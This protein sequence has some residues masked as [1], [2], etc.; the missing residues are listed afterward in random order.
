MLF[1]TENNMNDTANFWTPL[2]T[3]F[4]VVY[5]AAFVVLVGVVTCPAFN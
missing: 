4:A 3:A 5:L 2:R 1:F